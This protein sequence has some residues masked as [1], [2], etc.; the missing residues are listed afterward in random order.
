MLTRRS[1]FAAALR[2]RIPLNKLS[3]WCAADGSDFPYTSWR[4]RRG[5]I[6]AI[7]GLEIFQDIR[8]RRT[9]QDF[10]FHFKF[11]LTPGGNSGVKYLIDRSD[12][13]RGH[14]RA[15]GL[16]FQLIDDS[17]P[18]AGRPDHR[19]GALYNVQGPNIPAPFRAGEWATGKLVRRGAHIEHWLNGVCLLQHQLPSSDATRSTPIALQNHHDDCAF[20]GLW[21][22]PL[23]A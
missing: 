11:L 7:G 8:T 5:Q 12:S 10:E 4:Y 22:R 20:R 13:F 1:L 16:E 17:S 18:A 3:E 19:C 6:E 9:F 21:V 23:Q 15:R 14:I 2:P